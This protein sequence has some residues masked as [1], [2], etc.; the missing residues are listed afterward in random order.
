MLGL[1]PW[2]ADYDVRRDL[3]GDIVAG[4]T[5]F[6]MLVPQ[7]MAYAM[8][9]GL[10]PVV[11]LYASILPLV[12]YALVGTARQL[13]VGPVAM[14]S[15]LVATGAALVAPVGSPEFGVAAI[16]LAGL[17]GLLQVLMGLLRLGFLVNFL[18]RPVISG[19]TSAAAIV[20]GASQLKHIVGVGLPRTP[21]IQAF[22]LEAAPRLLEARALPLTLGVFGVLGLVLLKRYLPKVPAA[23]VVV[24]VSTLVS[25][26]LGLGA[27]G[28][29]IVGEVPAGLPSFSLQI[30]DVQTLQVL[31]PTAFMIALI[32]FMEAISVAKAIAARHGYEVDSNRE[33]VGL[34]AAN[35]AAYVTGGYPVT[36][37]F[38]RSAVNDQAGARSPL[39]GVIAAGLMALALLFMTSWFYHLPKAILASIVLV[40][41]S[42]LIDL[43]EPV[44]LW[45]VRRADAVLLLLT[46]CI[47]LSVGIGQG[48]LVGV[49]ASLAAFIKR[50]TQPHTAELG[51]LP[52]TN[53]YRNVLNYPEAEPIAGLLIL[54]MDASFYFANV[55][56]FKDRL[57]A[58]LR[59]APAG[60]HTVLIDAS[61]INDLDSSAEDA[62]RH[63]VRRLRG[64][65]RDMAF[66]N[67]KGPVRRV[68]QRSGLWEL[69]GPE[70][71]FWDIERAVVTLGGPRSGTEAS[72]QTAETPSAPS[73][74]ASAGLPIAGKSG[75]VA[76]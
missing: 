76:S 58:F 16:V 12:A 21:T 25:A 43:H 45:R 32:G 74:V 11:G 8:L 47:T 63:T 73:A 1:L 9:A 59:D 37:G 57:E 14:D 7:G 75:A 52:G 69:V 10:P 35:L 65:G 61:S 56:F 68:M 28:L 46:F 26:G 5:V 42:G 50:S 15:L 36:G 22:L 18:S 62:L 27:Q 54:R 19:F 23:L 48:I 71:F 34:G 64:E 39:A 20:I 41:V 33:L 30:L 51:R 40:A 4:L 67:V 17:T 44:R 72:P 31:L 49:V 3:R 38:S 66:A 60:V 2:R 70:R 6:V 29:P 13:A 24:L 55:A 53:V